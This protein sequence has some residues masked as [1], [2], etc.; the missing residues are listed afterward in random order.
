M[1]N[2]IHCI[3]EKRP[4][5]YVNLI[6]CFTDHEYGR[7]ALERYKTRNPGSEFFYKTAQLVQEVQGNE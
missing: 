2:P 6:V 4:Q 1:D 5:G 7:Q 3:Y